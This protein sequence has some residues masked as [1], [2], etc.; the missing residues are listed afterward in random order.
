MQ[1]TDMAS[2]QVCIIWGR[3]I[4]IGIIM[5]FN[6]DGMKQLETGIGGDDGVYTFVSIKFH[7]MG[8]KS[9]I[10]FYRFAFLLIMKS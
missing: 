2:W 9:E 6:P 3:D 10:L 4:I 5:L 7:L 8:Q 1:P